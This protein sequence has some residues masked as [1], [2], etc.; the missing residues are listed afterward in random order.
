MTKI[1]LLQRRA[2]RSFELTNVVG[3]V[4]G[5]I[6]VLGVAPACFHGVELRGVGGQPLE[7]D[8]LHP[9]RIYSFGRRAMDWPVVET[10]NQR[11]LELL[12]QGFDEADDFI[13]PDVLFVNLKRRADTASCGGKC[14][15]S[16]HAQTVVAKPG[17]LERRLTGWRPGAPIQR[18]QAEAGFVDKN[19]GCASSASFF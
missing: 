3:H 17:F 2:S 4:V 14:D 1:L 6:R 12:T 9:G 8:V 10:D 15:G 11:T 19:N 13:R 16:N 7:F 18:L 5:Q